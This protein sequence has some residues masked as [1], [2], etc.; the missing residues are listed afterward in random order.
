MSLPFRAAAFGLCLLASAG[1]ASLAQAAPG[2]RTPELQRE[3]DAAYEASRLTVAVQALQ[4]GNFGHAYDLAHGVVNGPRFATLPADL[5]LA[6]RTV[7]AAGASGLGRHAEAQ[8]IVR[9]MTAAPDA[10]ADLWLTQLDIDAAAEDNAAMA[11]TL[12]EIARRYPD[13]LLQMEEIY[14][15]YVASLA[16]QGPEAFDLIEALKAAGWDTQDPTGTDVLS[17]DQALRWL[18]RGDPARAE[19]HL[20][21]ITSPSV[22]LSVETDHRFATLGRGQGT[23]NLE[24]EIARDLDASRRLV[25]THPE[26]LRHRISLAHSL[27]MAGLNDEALSA[28]EAAVA[29][30]S[31]GPDGPLLFGFALETQ[32]RM[33]FVLGRH[34]EAIAVMR[35]AAAVP[36]DGQSNISQTLEL[37]DLYWALGDG[38]TALALVRNL[39]RDRMD[40]FGRLSRATSEVCATQLTGDQALRDAA[41]AELAAEWREEPGLYIAAL[42]CVED[43]ETAVAVT[44]ERLA[45]PDM[46]AAALAELHGYRIAGQSTPVIDRFMAAWDTLRTDPQVQA[47]AARHGQIV[48]TPFYLSVI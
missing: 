16:G 36:E 27:S 40:R 37:S 35:R 8:A 39:D 20:A 48:D 46:R 2:A 47:A 32:A 7:Q 1:A 25:E 10:T 23:L 13:Q 21:D 19:A 29:L 43:H 38:D 17:R 5:Q 45:D 34:D 26:L 28:A 42:M 33:L 30:G 3:E 18:E 31:R 14:V 15:A 12:T 24:A 11:L 6:A 9:Q 41:L 4:S 44:L 22:L